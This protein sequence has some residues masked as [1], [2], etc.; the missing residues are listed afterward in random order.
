[1]T[2]T[3]L[4]VLPS[5][6]CLTFSSARASASMSSLLMSLATV[7]FALSLPFT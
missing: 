4:M 5:V 1:M 6:N 7:S 2:I 3:F